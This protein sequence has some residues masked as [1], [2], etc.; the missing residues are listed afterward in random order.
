MS[1]REGIRF[2]PAGL[3]FERDRGAAVKE[4]L[5]GQA[6]L[7]V[8]QGS[9]LV[10]VEVVGRGPSDR[11]TDL[12]DQTSRCQLLEGPQR[13]FF[14]PPGSVQVSSPTSNSPFSTAVK[15]SVRKSGR[16]SVSSLS[17][18]LS[19][20]APGTACPT[21]SSTEAWPNRSRVRVVALHDLLASASS[22]RR[23]CT[24]WISSARQVRS[25]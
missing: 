14:T 20:P 23:R 24:S 1:Y 4:T 9:Q 10:V 7:L 3:S 17:R 6:G 16:P 5:A 22:S 18:V 8:D 2:A 21:S 15:Y 19:I 25:T 11:A 12:P 13:L